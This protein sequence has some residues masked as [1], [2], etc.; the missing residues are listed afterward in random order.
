[1]LQQNV[2]LTVRALCL[3]LPILAAASPVRAQDE[4][5]LVSDFVIDDADPESSVPMP[6]EAMRKP[7]HMGY[8][9]MLLSE[10]ADAATARGDHV[11]AAKYWRAL[12][13]AVPDRSLPSARAC[14]S[15][16]AAGDYDSALQE[17]RDALGKEGVTVEDNE[18][19]VS[20]L[21]RKTDPLSDTDIAD[22]EAVAKHLHE[23]LD[24]EQGELQQNL[25]LCQ[26]ATRL[27]DA[28]RLRACTSRLQALAP[29]AAQTFVFTWSLAMLEHDYESA[30]SV[31]DDAKKASAADSIVSSMQSA[32]R[33]AT[34]QT[35]QRDESGWRPR[36]SAVTGA[37]ALAALMLLAVYKLRQR[38][39]RT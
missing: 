18:R 26:L 15:F 1:M 5:P 11:A 33:A 39:T 28:A 24:G 38:P 4:D 13:K 17:C 10:R 16:E 7:L 23:Q 37:L 35:A 6:E 25:L 19:F 8:H 32:L 34:A 9:L 12:G 36:L 21:L 14:K 2:L 3:A 31:I 22:V 29:K 27:S 30:S 20:L